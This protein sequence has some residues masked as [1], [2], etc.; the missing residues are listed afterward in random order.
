VQVLADGSLRFR[1][2]GSGLCL[3]TAPVSGGGVALDNCAESATQEFLTEYLGNEEFQLHS[4]ADQGLCLNISHG[5]TNPNDAQGLILYECQNTP[6]ERWVF[7]PADATTGAEPNPV[8]LSLDYGGPVTLESMRDAASPTWRAPRP[9]TTPR[10]S[11]ST[12]TAAATRAGTWTGSTATRS[13]SRTSPAQVPDILNSTN[14]V[15]AG[16]QLVVFDCHGGQLSQQVAGAATGQR[17]LSSATPT[18]WTCAWTS[19]APTD[20]TTAT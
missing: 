15:A 11:P 14:G 7:T 8:N 9:P 12:A 13:R 5:Q 4:V 3:D 18:T 17:Q 16:R 2:R 19:P 1:G 10:P 20:P 6:N